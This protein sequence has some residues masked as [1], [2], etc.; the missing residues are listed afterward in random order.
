VEYKNS[1]NRYGLLNF[2]PTGT[3]GQTIR[4]DGSDPTTG[5]EFTR[6]IKVE[7]AGELL[8]ADTTDS[9]TS[10]A[11]DVQKSSTAIKVTC[12][13][14]WKYNGNDKKISVSEILTNWRPNY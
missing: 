3:S 12:N 2:N 11:T 9:T 8:P 4:I 6:A 14:I 1:F 7:D 10:A 13:V 5:T